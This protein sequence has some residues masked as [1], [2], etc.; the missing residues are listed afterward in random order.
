MYVSI[1]PIR[2]DRIIRQIRNKVGPFF[3]GQSFFLRLVFRYV[4]ISTHSP[5]FD[6]KKGL[7]PVSGFGHLK[8]VR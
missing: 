5:H 1:A 6:E 8:Y 3:W 2:I 4:Y 7:V